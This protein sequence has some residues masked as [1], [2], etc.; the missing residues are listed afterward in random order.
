MDLS[1]LN[2]NKTLFGDAYYQIGTYE[3]NDSVCQKSVSLEALQNSISQLVDMNLKW[4]D[5]NEDL[6]RFFSVSR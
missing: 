5:K 4:A 3:Q 1:L 2:G 6:L